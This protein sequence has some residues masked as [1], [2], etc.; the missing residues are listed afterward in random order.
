MAPVRQ[1]ADASLLMFPEPHPSLPACLPAAARCP[2]RLTWPTCMRRAA[3]QGRCWA[4]RQEL[5]AACGQPLHAGF[6]IVWRCTLWHAAH[7]SP[8][9]GV[10]C[11]CRPKADAAQCALQ[12]MPDYFPQLLAWLDAFPSKQIMLLQVGG[13][14]QAALR[15]GIA[16]LSW[17]QGM[18]P[19]PAVQLLLALQSLLCR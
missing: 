13:P 10:C 3:S 9:T 5:T 15:L 2:C 18:H 14:S 1:P 4:E 16:E 17:M 11:P 12:E 19:E 6:P 8:S 7:P